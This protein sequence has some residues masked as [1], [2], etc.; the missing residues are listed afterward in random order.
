MTTSTHTILCGACKRPAETVPNPKPNDEVACPRCHRRDRYDHVM[1]SV[2][3]YIEHSL[4]QGI[5]DSFAKGLR[6]SKF[7]K[8]T[9]QR[10]SQ[11]SFRWIAGNLNL[12]V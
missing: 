1:R 10:P 8:L 6:G 5:H 12:G 9:S 7:I 3:D 11:R 2:K 4:A